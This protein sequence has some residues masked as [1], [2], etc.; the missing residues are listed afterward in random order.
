MASINLRFCISE[1]IGKPSPGVSNCS[2]ASVQRGFGVSKYQCQIVGLRATRIDTVV[3]RILRVRVE[4]NMGV[5]EPG[6]T[7]VIAEV[8]INGIFRWCFGNGNDAAALNP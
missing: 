2:K 7:G 3:G 5:Y 6:K 4:V 1:C 8:Q